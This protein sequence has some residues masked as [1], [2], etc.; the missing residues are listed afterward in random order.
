MVAGINNLDNPR[1]E[2]ASY[3]CKK[4]DKKRFL[5]S[6]TFEIIAFQKSNCIKKY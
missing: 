6:C 5:Y 4:E 1:L 2:F 3:S